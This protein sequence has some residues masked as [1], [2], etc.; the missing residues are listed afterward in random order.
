MIEAMQKEEQFENNQQ[1][2]YSDTERK[3]SDDFRVKNPSMDENAI[4]D[5]KLNFSEEDIPEEPTKTVS[6]K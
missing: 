5:V 3:M 4:V 2:I 1:D 6:P